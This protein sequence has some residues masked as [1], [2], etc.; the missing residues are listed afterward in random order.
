MKSVLEKF[1]HVDLE[2]IQ[3]CLPSMGDIQQHDLKVTLEL[4]KS[5]FDSKPSKGEKNILIQEDVNKD[6]AI[7]IVS[8]IE[9][10]LSKQP[11]FDEL[12]FEV[13]VQ[14]YFDV[15]NMETNVL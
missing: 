13:N 1:H 14:L 2:V 3:P 7:N 12:P 8:E 4:L 5:D 10:P 15:P 11:I 6:C 9:E